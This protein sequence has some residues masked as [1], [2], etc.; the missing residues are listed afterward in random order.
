[1]NGWTVIRISIL[2][3]FWLRECVNFTGL[4]NCDVVNKKVGHCFSNNEC[5]ERARDTQ[6]YAPQEWHKVKNENQKTILIWLFS[7]TQSIC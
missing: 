6:K 7:E 1:M 5:G 3:F 4:S 2:L